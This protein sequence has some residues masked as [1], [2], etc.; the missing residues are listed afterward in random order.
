MRDVR[1]RGFAERSDV[2]QVLQL[3]DGFASALPAETASLA[4]CAGRVLAEPVVA[5]V[6]VRTE[7]DEITGLERVTF[8]VRDRSAE[9]L[10]ADVL[11]SRYIEEGLGLTA[12]LVSRYD[13]SLDVLTAQEGWT[14]A[15][16]MALPRA[17]PKEEAA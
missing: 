2:E 9:V 14:K 5:G 12:D 16:A 7:V 3:L 4:D 1:M 10:S 6:D 17:H 15:V 11:H 8:L 13:G